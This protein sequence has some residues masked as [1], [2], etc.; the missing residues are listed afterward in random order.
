MRQKLKEKFLQCLND[1][2]IKALATDEEFHYQKAVEK[3]EELMHLP[4]LGETETQELIEK[5]KELR[6]D[7]NFNY[8]NL[9]NSF[10]KDTNTYK[11]V[12]CIGELIAYIDF[13]AANKK[14]FN[15]YTDTRTIA[16]SF[17]RQNVWVSNLLNYKQY[18]D[19]NELPGAVKN[20]IK[21]LINPEKVINVLSEKHRKLICLFLFQDASTINRFEDFIRSEMADLNLSVENEKN[22]MAYYEKLLYFKEIRKLW[23]IDR[24]IW[25]ISHGN[26]GSFTDE[27]RKEYLKNKIVTVHKDTGKNQGIN[28]SEKMKVG[29]LF[30]L[31]YG[32][33]EVKLLGRITSN[34]RALRGTEDGWLE[35]DYEII[36]E[37]LSKDRYRGANLGWAPNY[38]ST[39]MPVK[40]EQLNVFEKDLLLPY[41]NMRV[42]ELLSQYG[43]GVAPMEPEED[44][45]RIEE[46]AEEFGVDKSIDYFDEL[47]YILY[48]P[49]GTGK[50]YNSIN[51]AVAILERKEPIVV[52]SDEYSSVKE[53]FEK[54]KEQGQVL[55]TT[56]H[57]SY[58]YEE[59]IEGIKP[60]L[61][62]DDKADISYKLENGIF[63]EICRRA[64]ENKKKNYVLIIDEINRGNI[65]KI[66]GELITLIEKTKRIG[67]PEETSTTLPYSK[68]EF[69]VPKNVY[70]LGT[71]NTADRSIALLD[72]ALRRR[73]EF[74]EMMPDG[75]IFAKL[76]NNSDLFVEGVN[77]KRLLNMINKRIEILY[78]REHTIGQAYFMD[79]INNNSIDNL[80][81]IFNRKVIPLLQEYFYEDYEKIRLVL[82]DNQVQDEELQFIGV[83]SIPYNLFGN[84]GD[85]DYVED[86]KVYT[87]NKA[88]FS[89]P[90]AYKKIYSISSGEDN[91]D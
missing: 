70:I 17:V 40:D 83:T 10:N 47:N 24:T 11:V 81:D 77:I 1:D 72:T 74:I 78:D 39:C 9:L 27:E 13:Q 64:L 45:G 8:M 61:N 32:G 42:D 73:F 62:G 55:F 80:A 6:D 31:C 38:N 22:R 14:D 41:F 43:N 29:D 46:E 18:E 25:K 35:R 4:K 16:K 75:D 57:Q 91:N 26:N 66:F 69:G 20:A 3:Y 84:L 68:I 23:D 58:G 67:T 88:A 33:S 87:V 19:V 90:E 30:Y 15:K 89:N 7:N 28:F 2:K 56:F 65:S 5:V 86:K 85:I 44:N 37:S 53:R 34:P 60:C 71:M 49:P 48:G 79:L 54:F 52:Q 82:A 12:L 51:Y 36:K 76:N 59:F 50:T 63:K 21:F